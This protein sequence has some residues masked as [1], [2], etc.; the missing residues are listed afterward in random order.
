MSSIEGTTHQIDQ[1]L[2]SMGSQ[3]I[4]TWNS[5]LKFLFSL[6]TTGF[7]FLYGFLFWA[8]HAASGNQFAFSQ[9]KAA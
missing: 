2:C 4:H 7:F 5:N 8:K 9:S 6:P 1:N 3:I